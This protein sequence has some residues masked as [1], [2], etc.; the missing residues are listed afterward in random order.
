VFA[1]F[2]LTVED[3]QITDAKAAF[4]GMAA[5]PK[6]ARTV[7][8]KLRGLRLADPRAWQAA[9]DGVAE[10]FTPLTDM[11]ASATYRRRVA[12][13][14]VVK[15]LAEITGATDDMTRIHARGMPAHAS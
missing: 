11:R 3:G 9:A 6:R 15:A 7:E 12:G 14:L 1:A 5:I 4:G 2:C 10:D 13:N 8:A